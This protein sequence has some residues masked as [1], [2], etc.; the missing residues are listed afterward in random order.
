MTDLVTVIDAKRPSLTPLGMLLEYQEYATVLRYLAARDIRLRFR[1]AIL[2]LA[3]VVL[4]PLLPMMV[5][6]LVFSQVLRPS[7]I[8][9]VPY[10]LFAL[11]GMAVWSYFSGAVSVASM[12][13]VSNTGLLNKVYFPR[14]IL[15]LAA[16]LATALDLAVGLLLVCG[17]ST[18]LGFG[19]RWSWLLLP[20]IAVETVLLAFF[21]SLALATLNIL[22]RDVKHAL[23]FVIQLWMFASPVV[24]APSLLEE[25]VRWMM[26]L[27]P[28]TCVLLGAR[29]ALLGGPVEAGLYW[30][31]TGS[32]VSVAFVAV[33][34]FRHYERQLP[35][36]S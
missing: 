17:Y 23:Q 29:A 2:G 28:V 18:F 3:W 22:Y 31:S 30:T 8:P 7:M 26:G 14:G 16:V 25:N 33:L 9:G 32:A 1:N 12:S 36:R 11:A 10:S 20:L 35:E 34:I 13:F 24:Y 6:A 19:P 27:N 5:F 21:V 15:P 4:Q